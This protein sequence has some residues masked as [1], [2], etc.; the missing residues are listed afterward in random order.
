MKR[1]F[2][3][4][5]ILLLTS[6]IALSQ[7]EPFSL[8]VINTK[9]TGTTNDYRLAHP[10]EI[11]YGRDNYL[12]ITEKVGRVLRVDPSTGLRQIILDYRANTYLNITRDGSGAATGIGQDGMMGM[13][14]HPNFGLGTGQ[15]SIFIAY[16]RSAG[17]LRISRFKYNGGASPSLTNETILVQG[18]PANNDHSSG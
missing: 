2:P 10:F 16:T 17:N 4:I 13:A 7:G 18:I 14:L 6:Y 11:L 12:Y 15:D 5:A 1:S 3:L 9:P 8:S